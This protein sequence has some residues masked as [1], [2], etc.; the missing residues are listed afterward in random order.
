LKIRK[1]VEKIQLIKREILERDRTVLEYDK[2]RYALNNE[3]K[4]PTPNMLTL[5]TLQ[6]KLTQAKESYEQMNTRVLTILTRVNSDRSLQKEV[7]LF[8]ASLAEFF[9]TSAITFSKLQEHLAQT[10][11]ISNPQPQGVKDNTSSPPPQISPTPDSDTD[12]QLPNTT[13][14]TFL[15]QL[16]ETLYPFKGADPSELDFAADEVVTVVK[17]DHPDWWSGTISES[18]SG[19]FPSNYVRLLGKSP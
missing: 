9:S 7:H 17:F 14:T 10:P 6:T 15:P 13:A 16:A 11:E 12:P 3:Q 5:Q 4:K 2:A 1:M 18:R 8:V 19:R